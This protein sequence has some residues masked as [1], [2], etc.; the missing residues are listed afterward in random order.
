MTE[1]TD[2]STS[3]AIP[4]QLATLVPSFDPSKDDLQVYSQKVHLLLQAWPENKYTELVTRLILNTTGSAFKKLQLKQ[5]DLLVN[6]KESVGKLV[7][8]LGGHWGRIGLERKYEYAEKALYHCLQKQ[9]ESADSFLARAD[10][11]W[12]ELNS[13]GIA[14][15]DLQSYVTLR[16]SGLSAE[17]KKRVLL[18][19]DASGSGKLEVEKVSSAIRMLGAGFFHDMTG[20]RRPK[21]KIYDHLTLVTEAHDD[22]LPQETLQAEAEEAM[23]DED[24]IETLLS[25]GDGDAVFVAEYE[26]AVADV[27]Q[28]DGELAA[29]YNTYTEARRRLTEKF[30]SRGFW[31]IS[32]P[33]KGKGKGRSFGKGKIRGKFQK[34]FSNR[35]SLSH[36]ILN[37]E[38]RIC[39]NMGHWKAECPER[40]KNSSAP[41]VAPT[42]FAHAA[43][44]V[45]AAFPMEFLNLPNDAA[46]DESQHV[47]CFVAC[48][49]NQDYNRSMLRYYMSHIQS[50]STVGTGVS[51][52]MNRFSSPRIE[53]KSSTTCESLEPESM[54]CFATHGTMRVVDLGAT[55][56]VIGSELVADL[57]NSLQPK[58]QQQ[59][60]RCACNITFRFGNHGTLNSKQALV[61]PIHGFQLKIAIVPGNTP[62]LV[63]NTLLRALKALIDVD[64]HT[65]WSKK[66]NREFPM[67]LSPRGLFL[68][69]L[70]DLAAMEDRNPPPLA[71]TH[72]TTSREETISETVQPP[73]S[74]THVHKSD[75]QVTGSQVQWSAQP[76]IKPVEKSVESHAE[77]C[78]SKQPIA[79]ASDHPIPSEHGQRPCAALA[80][81]P[82][83]DR[84]ADTG[85]QSLVPDSDGRDGC[86]F[87]SSPQGQDLQDGLGQRPS[88]DRLVCGQIS[89]VTQDGSSIA[90]P[91]CAMS[92]GTSRT[93]RT[94]G[95][96]DSLRSEGNH[97]CDGQSCIAQ[98]DANK[99]LHAEGQECGSANA[100]RANVGSTTGRSSCRDHGWPDSSKHQPPGGSHAE[101]G[102]HD[103][104]HP[105]ALGS[106]EP[107]ESV[108]SAGSAGQRT[109]GSAVDQLLISAGEV[110]DDDP[111]LFSPSTDV[112]R[113]KERQVFNQLVHKFQLELN[114]IVS[115]SQAHPQRFVQPLQILEVFC[116][117]NSQIIHQGAQLGY[118]TRRLGLEQCDLQSKDGRQMLFRSLVQESPE[119]VWYSP[120]CGPWSGW[121]NLNGSQSVAAFDQLCADR[122][123]HVEQVALGIVILRHQ[124]LNRRHF[125]W[126]QPKTSLMLKLPYLSELYAYTIAATFDMCQAGKLR[127]PVS[128]LAIKKGMTVM[129]TSQSLAQFLETQ[130]C[131]GNHAHQVIEGV[132]KYQGQTVNRSTFTEHYPRRFA[133]TVVQ[134]PCKLRFP[135]EPP[136]AMLADSF[137]SSSEPLPK[138][139][140][141]TVVPK[142]KPAR[143]SE[144]TN[145]MV[146]KR[147]K[148]HGKQ[149]PLK[150]LDAW[151]AIFDKIDSDLPRVGR[152]EI[153]DSQIIQDIQDMFQDK[154]IKRIIAC[155]GTN[156]T[157]GPP[158]NMSP[159]EAPF[160][161]CAYLKRGTTQ[162]YTEDQWENWEQLSQR[163]LVRPSHQ[164]RI[165][166]TV[167]ACNPIVSSPSSEPARCSECKD[168]PSAS[169]DAGDVDQDSRRSG[170]IN[171]P[172]DTTQPTQSLQQQ[173]QHHPEPEQHERF[174]ALSKE[175]QQ[176]IQRSHQNLGHP[177]PER[178]S[179]ILRQ[180]GFRPEVCQAALQWK[181]PTCAQHSAPKSGR[182]GTI[183]DDSDFNDRISIDGITW[184]NASGQHFNIYHVIDWST[185]FHAAAIAPART[186]ESMTQALGQMW[187][188]WAGI[189]GEILVDA[190]SEFNSE[191]FMTF[192]QSRNIKAT[193]ISTEAHHQNGKIE[194][195]GS[196][197]Q[198]MLSK[199]E[200]KHQIHNYTD[201]QQALWWCIQA[202]NASSIRRGFA[203]E[204][205]VLGKHTRMPGSITSDSLIPAHALAD[206][207]S[208]QGLQFRQQLAYRECARRA[209]HSAD[210]DAAIRKAMLR[211]STPHRGHY[212]PGEWVMVWKPAN[213]ISA[214]NHGMWIGPMKVIVQEG[215][216]TIWAT[217]SSKLFR[218]APENV[219]PV[220]SLEAR[221]I[222][223][224]PNEPS[225][226]EIARHI[227][228]RVQG[229]ITQYRD[230]NNLNRP[231]DQIPTPTIPNTVPIEIPI[232]VTNNN[233]VPSPIP[234]SNS[235]EVQ[236]D[237]EPEA[238]SE[239]TGDPGPSEAVNPVEIPVPTEDD[240]ELICEGLYSVDVEPNA[241]DT[242]DEQLAWKF[243]VLITEHDINQ[244]KQEEHPEDMAFLVSA[245]KKQRAEVK[246]SQ[247]NSEEK[248][249]FDKAKQSEVQNWLKTGTV[250]KI[251]RSKLSPEQILRCRW[252]LT[253]KPI[254][255]ADRVNGKAQKAKARLVVL[256]YLDPKITE[257]PRD[258]P[259]LG[260]HSKLLLLQLIAARGWDLR[261]FDVKA[262]FLQ[263]QP[264]QGR[265]L[266]LEPVPELARAMNIS[267]DEVCRLTKGAYGLID[268][269]YLCTVP[270]ELSS[271]DWDSNSPLS[272]LVCSFSGVPRRIYLMVFLE[273]MWMTVFV[274][275]TQDFS[276]KSKN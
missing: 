250:E 239:P 233:T 228:T 253:W 123:K 157:I 65:I 22:D 155:R 136:V 237:Q 96:F 47:E 111:T 49:D 12:S 238:I 82:C 163:Q 52:L 195:H 236:P 181:C 69:D 244:W 175:E 227:P 187:I 261:S 64:N 117:P 274:V 33:S 13:Q 16:G 51:S 147:R 75:N 129:T 251:L 135:R 197:L 116:G 224:R 259:T 194:R 258:S 91:L 90:D 140:R 3:G 148:L 172:H 31:P 38:C 260:R 257:V 177:N 103:A 63:S 128:G 97:E 24:M 30:Q 20:A 70:N 212:V 121:S 161:K 94:S 182:P 102:D 221:D 242:C 124:R 72:L 53:P 188:S 88:M 115:Q 183:R 125:H 241:L 25:E 235:S 48:G 204:V 5:K 266:G 118:A 265:I 223:V 144:M 139:R 245:S 222:T 262:A 87:R 270:S 17:D 67:Q 41:A 152:I 119:H 231:D 211:R 2:G 78:N 198:T 192:L 213:S 176:L 151:T 93:G 21:G 275:V 44:D 10:I 218:A 199:F 208:A 143:S 179:A 209:F 126:E 201:L 100:L 219:R 249:E 95:P 168:T 272:I 26:N 77:T 203:P 74:M 132:T 23:D 4:N 106:S 225:V 173:E 220:S 273:F 268:A 166:I 205:L 8:V 164:C 246:L 210:N 206:S 248:L 29:A 105:D 27:I 216:H 39:H 61:V 134:I 56:T 160:R 226:S 107:P 101:Y 15:A 66:L 202:K 7:E 130:R 50:K 108:K 45:S 200:V 14:L 86:R 141:L 169:T 59:L 11:M 54:T 104:N 131:R 189:P 89:K 252:I 207:E 170:D 150:A 62:F 109:L 214:N 193:T 122:L 60:K 247:L 171:V 158:K 255:E 55:K 263:G 40:G 92:N 46:I 84:S 196:V 264:Q 174:I 269:P 190:G 76:I 217:M 71:D 42:S 167:F 36:R 180:Q 110:I 254:E 267:A 145:E 80:S 113:N 9:D 58:I 234:E 146:I 137:A 154:H 37:S 232:P 229:D 184:T 185:N 142:P 18:D 85:L 186:T 43:E 68:I 81:T 153:T 6:S 99:L 138:R 79:T 271:C 156:R 243:E 159:G 178:L 28:G 73:C 112:S 215:Q 230:M 191:E 34:G 1:A 83:A 240:D 276:P 19:S 165:N 127:D 133:R 120:T 32:Q 35:R 256:G 57:I 98:D 162:I 149:S 114:A